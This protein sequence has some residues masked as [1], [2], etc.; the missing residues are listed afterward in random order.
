M[1]FDIFIN[2]LANEDSEFDQVINIG[3]NSFNSAMYS[4]RTKLI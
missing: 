4:E 1:A 3:L 2:K